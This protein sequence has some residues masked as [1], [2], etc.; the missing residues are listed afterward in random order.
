MQFGRKLGLPQDMKCSGVKIDLH[1]HQK[2]SHQIDF[3]SQVSISELR[4]LLTESF[5]TIDAYLMSDLAEIYSIRV[6]GKKIPKWFNHQ[7]TE[8][9]IFF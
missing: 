9:S 6:P 8:S 4:L 3:S 5:P 2:L 1:S 7:S